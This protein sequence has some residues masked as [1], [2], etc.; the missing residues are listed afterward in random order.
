MVHRGADSPGDSTTW[1]RLGNRSSWS[2]FLIGAGE[3]NLDYRGAALVHHI[4]GLGGG[5]LAAFND[6][7]QAQFLRNDSI[8]KVGTLGIHWA[9]SLAKPTK[10]AKA[11]KDFFGLTT[12]GGA[13]GAN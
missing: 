10:A 3:G 1:L 5:L 8:R 12:D 13:V 6:S 4:P 7:G 9:F 2:G 11:R